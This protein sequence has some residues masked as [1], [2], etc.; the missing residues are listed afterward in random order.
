MDFFQSGRR[1][2]GY[3]NRMSETAAAEMINNGGTSNGD[4]N[5]VSESTPLAMA[6]F[7][8]QRFGDLYEPETALSEGTIF[9][10]LD[11]PFEAAGGRR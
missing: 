1:R 7:P 8:Y 6:Y 9:R 5:T 11:K 10:K 3:G 2:N 4:V